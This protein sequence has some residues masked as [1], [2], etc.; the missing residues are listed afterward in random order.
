MEGA[1]VPVP[2]LP[3]QPFCCVNA[4]CFCFLRLFPSCSS[5]PLAK[6]KNLLELLPSREKLLVQTGSCPQPSSCPATAAK[7]GPAL[8]F[9]DQSHSKRQPLPR[10]GARP[11]CTIFVNRF[12]KDK[13]KKA[14]CTVGL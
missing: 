13:K 11:F 1:P 8:P 5:P 9:F 12:Y 10:A 6:K 2:Q 7:A 14:F 3:L 4:S